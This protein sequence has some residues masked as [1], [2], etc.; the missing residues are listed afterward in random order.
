MR[1]VD[2][3]LSHIIGSWRLLHSLKFASKMSGM[4]VH[5]IAIVRAMNEAL[6]HTADVSLEHIKPVHLCMRLQR[7]CAAS[8]AQ[9]TC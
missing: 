3:R 4:F 1:Y 7:W 6:G 2:T 5:L 9:P 8:D